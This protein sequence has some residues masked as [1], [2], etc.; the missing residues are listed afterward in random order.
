MEAPLP[1]Q[2]SQSFSTLD[3][4]LNAT[5]LLEFCTCDCNGT[6]TTCE[7]FKAGDASIIFT[8]QNENGITNL[9]DITANGFRGPAQP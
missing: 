5:S 4:N 9:G 1:S 7:L 6:E 8:G 3:T 2:C